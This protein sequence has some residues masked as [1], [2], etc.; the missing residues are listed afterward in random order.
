MLKSEINIQIINIQYMKLLKILMFCLSSIVFFL[1]VCQLQSC[2]HEP[3]SLSSM[4]TVCFDNQIQPILSSC[5]KCHSGNSGEGGFNPSNYSTIM[6]SV[7]AGNPW[8]SKLYTIVS[9]PN[10]PNMMPPK[11]NEP[12][13]PEQRTLI[14]V[15]I[16]QG[17]KDTKC[18]T[19][20]VIK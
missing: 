1:I 5:T 4:P 17:A 11:G 18:D 9:S 12:L 13:S 7:K 20:S 3:A 15:W 14:E 10:N 8:G 16:L 19:T 2:K 6:E